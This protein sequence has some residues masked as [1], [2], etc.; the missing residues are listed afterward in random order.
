MQKKIRH[1]YLK[2]PDISAYIIISAAFLLLVSIVLIFKSPDGIWGSDKDWK[3]QHFA[4]PEYFRMRFYETH[5]PFPDLALQLGCGQNIYNYAYYGIFNPL[6]IPAYAMPFVRMSTYIQLLSLATVLVSAMLGYVLF[7]RHFDRKTALLLALLFLCSSGL[8]FHSHRHVMF[9]NYI[10]FL[11]GMLLICEKKDSPARLFLMAL[12]AYCI[13][14]CSFYFSISSFVVVGIHMIWL[15][16]CKEEKFSPVRTIADIWKKVTAAAFGCLCSSYLWMPVF[17]ALLSGR[18]ETSTDMSLKSVLIPTVNLSMILHTGYSVGVISITVFAAMYM[19]LHGQKQDRF[20]SAVILSCIVFPFIN[21]AINAGMYIDGKAFI[22]LIIPVLIICGR[23]LNTHKAPGKD[24][25]ILLVIHTAMA[26]ISLVFCTP[27]IPPMIMMITEYSVST[28]VLAFL[29]F[30]NKEKYLPH[31]TLLMSFAI[32]IAVSVNDIFAQRSS[33]DEFYSH[34]IRS[35]IAD[36]I[37]SDDDLYRFGDCIPDDIN[38]NRVVNMRYLSTNSYSSVSNSALRDFRFNTSLSENRIR[39]T[40]IQNQS[41]SIL[42]NALMGVRYKIA[43][44][45]MRMDGEEPVGSIN[46]YTIFRNNYAMP[47]GYACPAT[48]SEKEFYSLPLQLRAEALI[49]NIITP[50]GKDSSPKYASHT[51]EIDYDMTPAVNDKRISCSGDVYTIK[52]DE[53]FTVHVP[54]ERSTENKFLIVLAKADN[55]IG[56]ISAQ[57]DISLTINGVKNKLTDP[58]WKYNNRNY[59]FTFV[60]SSYDPVSELTMTFTKGYYRISELHVYE[61]DNYILSSA[62]N[63]KDAFMIDADDSVGD[64]IKGDISVSEDGWF[65]F[66]IPYDKGFH[67]SVDGKDTEYFKT[68]TAFIGFPIAAGEHHIDITFEAPLKK[69][70]LKVSVVSAIVLVLFIAAAALTDRKRKDK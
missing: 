3:S 55:R 62:M 45:T 57:T 13:M 41:Y 14:C 19:L 44:D 58:K 35:A 30:K 37:D 1:F 9:M 40:A 60:I 32:C 67:V 5:D 65:T 20:L 59:D 31:F 29:L 54:L 17:S 21:Y 46:G 18:A 47:L 51:R 24:I 61:A 70:G 25:A 39:N 53:N 42:F 36:T 38:V 56:H 22:P 64:T 43:P 52:S 15:E 2:H 68:N 34:E 63:N 4:I 66:S 26:V 10:P 69:T 12:F 33:I 6:Y 8:F 27:R 7:K 16:L 11:L 48:M 50:N 23:F 28:P 49:E